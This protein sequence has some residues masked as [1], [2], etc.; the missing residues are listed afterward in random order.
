M[1]SVLSLVQE[2]LGKSVGRDCRRKGRYGRSHFRG[3]LPIWLADFHYDFS[4]FWLPLRT[5]QSV[6]ICIWSTVLF[7]AYRVIV[8]RVDQVVYIFSSLTRSFE[9]ALDYPLLYWEVELIK[10]IGLRPNVKRLLADDRTDF[11]LRKLELGPGTTAI[12]DVWHLNWWARGFLQFSGF[13]LSAK[14]VHQI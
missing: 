12:H 7:R 8:L 3:I 9:R 4:S 6:R 5:L 10:L 14:H 1:L 2:H 13:L 11:W